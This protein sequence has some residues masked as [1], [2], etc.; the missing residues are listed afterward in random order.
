MKTDLTEA[1][2][3]AMYKTE[4][5]VLIKCAPS[6]RQTQQAKDRDGFTPARVAPRRTR[7]RILFHC[8]GGGHF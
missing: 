4:L 7:T 5:D 2:V 6:R 1:R 3:Q 8:C